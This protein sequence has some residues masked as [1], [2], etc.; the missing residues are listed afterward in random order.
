M[1]D[2]T[3]L[4]LYK[5]DGIRTH[6]LSGTDIN[7]MISKQSYFQNFN[8]FRKHAQIEIVK[9]STALIFSIRK[10]KSATRRD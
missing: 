9:I 5:P 6:V 4:Y 10:T 1:K 7:Y 3:T 8:V 2:A